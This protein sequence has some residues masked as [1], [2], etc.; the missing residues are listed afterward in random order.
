MAT[1][2]SM[3]G[4]AGILSII[5]Y[6]RGLHI[7]GFKIGSKTF[8][9][10]L[11]ILVACLT[12]AGMIQVL[13]PK[14]FFAKWLGKEAGIKGIFLGWIG[15]LLLPGGPLVVF[16]ILASLYKMGTSVSCLV[17]LVT[18]WGL[19]SIWK[20]PIEV[21]IIGPKFCLMRLASTLILP[22]IAGVLARHF[23]SS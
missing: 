9:N 11:P 20:L 13:I 12:I 22:P 23:F 5:A 1:I 21:G 16:P 14:E 2:I 15:G 18:A 19:G 6:S 10:I 3:F 17:T 7:E 8:I 4:L